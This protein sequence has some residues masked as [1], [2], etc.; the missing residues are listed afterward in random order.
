MRR[1]WGGEPWYCV[2]SY[3][4]TW[5]ADG[6][7]YMLYVSH[8]GAFLIDRRMVVTR[9]QLRFPAWSHA[10]IPD[11]S[12]NEWLS[13]FLAGRLPK[14]TL[15]KARMAFH[16][17]T[18]VEG[19]MVVD[20]QPD[21]RLE[22][23]FYVYDLMM[24]NGANVTV[25]PW[26]ARAFSR[27]RCLV[28]ELA[29]HLLLPW[30][31]LVM[32]A[33]ERAARAGAKPCARPMVPAGHPHQCAAHAAT[34]H[35]HQGAG[36]SPQVRAEPDRESSRELAA[37]LPVQCGAVPRRVQDLLAAARPAARAPSGHSSA[38]AR[39]RRPHPPGAAT[40]RAP[41]ACWSRES[42]FSLASLRCLPRPAPIAAAQRQYMPQTTAPGTRALASLSWMCAIVH[43]HATSAQGYES[44]YQPGPCHELL[45]WK[46]ASHN[47]VD[48]KLLH[49]TD[50]LVILDDRCS[51][52]IQADGQDYFLGVLERGRVTVAFDFDDD[53][54]ISSASPPARVAFPPDT[55]PATLV[56]VIIECNFDQTTGCWL[57]M[58]DRS[59]CELTLSA[60]ESAV[61]RM[62]GRKDGD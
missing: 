22:F 3:W 25:Y 59:K 27:Q 36:R 29:L 7:R 19:E 4:F 32:R 28:P 55:D 16:H 17:A 34:L 13:A 10:G 18:L 61:A 37:P 31:G 44:Q 58:R 2:R 48:F 40:S 23:V 15:H 60:G 53:L 38:A 41:Q 5:K 20:R 8:S 56:D 9:A 24:L 26:K 21:G 46:P 6:T 39:A 42:C 35:A 57:F 49:A 12:T 47:S 50:E 14:A 52:R 51:A 45:K 54:Q 30:P 62:N 43:R 33:G 1:D 11:G